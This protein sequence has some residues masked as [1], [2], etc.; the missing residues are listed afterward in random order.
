MMH[1]NMNVKSSLFIN[2]P[3]DIIG[4]VPSGALLKSSD[5]I[6]FLGKI[7]E[8]GTKKSTGFIL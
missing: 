5:F 6:F 3:S 8:G 2:P 4:T 7:V 1:G